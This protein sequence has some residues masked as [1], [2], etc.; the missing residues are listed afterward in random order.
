[1]FNKWQLQCDKGF[2]TLSWLRCDT[3]STSSF[4]TFLC[5]VCQKYET[6]IEGMKIFSRS[7]IVG[8]TNQRISNITDHRKTKRHK[9]AMTRLQIEQA[10]LASVPVTAY[11]P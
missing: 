8:S 1:M 11:S 4:K 3:D 5:I 10:K 7:W 6:T 2:S 9:A